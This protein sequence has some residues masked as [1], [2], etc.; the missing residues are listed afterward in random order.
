[1]RKRR[2][3]LTIPLLI[4]REAWTPSAPRRA[5]R[6][7]GGRARNEK[8]RL[9]APRMIPAFFLSP[10]R[11]A[12]P[13]PSGCP[14]LVRASGGGVTPV[15]IPNTAV[16]A[17]RGD[18][19]VFKST[20]KQRGA[21]RFSPGPRVLQQGIRGPFFSPARAPERPL[22]SIHAP[23]GG[24]RRGSGGLECHRREFFRRNRNASTIVCIVMVIIQE[25]G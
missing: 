8:A 25:T 19:T 20:G 9:C 23:T 1:M 7:A 2:E 14:L 5:R 12:V 18:D 17:P 10:F 15:P 13:C 4:G 3:A 22:V 24:V 21:N 16:K 11:S 6:R